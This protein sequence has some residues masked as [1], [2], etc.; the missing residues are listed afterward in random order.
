MATDDASLRQR[1][2]KRVLAAAALA[3][4]T[5]KVGLPIVQKIGGLVFGKKR[6]SASTSSKPVLTSGPSE[7][8]WQPVAA[9]AP[10]MPT[11][12]REIFSGT[13]PC[14]VNTFYRRFVSGGSDWQKKLHL[15]LEG[16]EDMTLGPWKQAPSDGEPAA[17]NSPCNPDDGSVLHASG[18]SPFS[19]V[20]GPT[21][22]SGPSTGFIRSVTFI[23]P[24]KPPQ[25]VDA[26]CVQRQQFC[27]FQDDVLVMAI[28]QN[29][30]NI[31]FKD[32]FT[33]NICWVVKP[34]PDGQSCTL[35]IFLKVNFLKGV[36]VGGI[37]KMTTLNSNVAF[38]KK[39]FESAN[40]VIAAG[41]PLPELTGPSS[42]QG[43]RGKGNAAFRAMHNGAMDSR[44]GGEGTNQEVMVPMRR[45]LRF[46]IFM[47]LIIVGVVNQVVLNKGMAEV[48][49]LLRK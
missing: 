18:R 17:P 43:I 42:S 27:V 19:F 3:V 47:I 11:D 15:E 33:V 29:M 24:K 45:Q 31:P 20:L 49:N 46:A 7:D 5:V 41:G 44:P 38:W 6:T 8:S 14:S 32:C 1:R 37:I 25:S 48:R 4:I 9:P 22:A 39:W 13:L 16:R 2:I 36:L 21:S 34:A 10:A 35:K 23:Q 30:L 26:E 28:A 12:M 40:K